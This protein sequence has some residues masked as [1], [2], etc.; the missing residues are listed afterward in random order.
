M[1]KSVRVLGHC[2]TGLALLWVRVHE[3]NLTTHSAAKLFKVLVLCVAV[4]GNMQGKEPLR[5]VDNSRASPGLRLLLEPWGLCPEITLLVM[6]R[7]L[8]KHQPTNLPPCWM[9]T[10]EFTLVVAPSL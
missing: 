2:S 4:Y 1:A 7:T 8:I 5:L 3:H 10:P 9:W 6:K